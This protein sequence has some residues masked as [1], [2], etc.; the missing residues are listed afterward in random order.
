MLTISQQI[1]AEESHE[2]RP[3][4]L[5]LYEELL[6]QRHVQAKAKPYFLRW[7][8]RSFPPWTL[9]P[10]TMP[11]TLPADAASLTCQRPSC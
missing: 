6:D 7:R 3:D 2:S 10:Q 4:Y 5:S 8:K 9:K 1:P 11:K